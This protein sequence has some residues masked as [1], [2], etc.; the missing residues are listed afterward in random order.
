MKIGTE[1]TNDRLRLKDQS[2][3][4]S[5]LITGFESLIAPFLVDGLQCHGSF[6]ISF[7]LSLAPGNVPK[8][9]WVTPNLTSSQHSDD[10]IGC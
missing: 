4:A 10:V 9:G 7:E 5:D 1:E 6:A 2:L 8:P 3:G